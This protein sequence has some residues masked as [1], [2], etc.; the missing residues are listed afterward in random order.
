[1]EAAT[2]MDTVV[3]QH[4][5]IGPQRD[6]PDQTVQLAAIEIQLAALRSLGEPNKVVQLQ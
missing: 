3:G 6:S 2:L 4:F 1:M 5:A